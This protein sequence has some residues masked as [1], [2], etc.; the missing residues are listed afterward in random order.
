MKTVP[1][2]TPTKSLPDAGFV[3]LP[4]ILAHFPISKSSWW[5]G[6]KAGRF[7]KPVKLGPRISAWRVEDIKALIANPQLAHAGENTVPARAMLNRSV[8]GRR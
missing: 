6:V 8:E 5:S 3:R 4:T 2:F 1:L 7:P